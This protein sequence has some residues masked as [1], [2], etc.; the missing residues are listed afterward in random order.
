VAEVWHRG[1][2]A[3]YGALI[4][5]EPRQTRSLRGAG[6]AGEEGEARARCADADCGGGW[7]MTYEGCGRCPSVEYKDSE[8]AVYICLDV[9]SQT[10]VQD[11]FGI[12]RLH[13]RYY[14]KIHVSS[15]LRT[16]FVA[17][18]ESSNNTRVLSLESW[19]VGKTKKRLRLKRMKRRS[20]LVF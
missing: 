9:L 12:H 18:L 14:I 7:D 5:S 3:S 15:A 11:T 17:S 6:E 19:G 20:S 10:I 8:E 2:L 13:I 1:L 4:G 16:S